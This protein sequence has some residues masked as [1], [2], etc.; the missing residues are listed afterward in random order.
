MAW[1]PSHT[2]CPARAK[3]WEQP[4]S[5]L[6][7]GS[8][9]GGVCHWWGWRGGE[10]GRAQREGGKALRVLGERRDSP[11]SR[12][13]QQSPSWAEQLSLGVQTLQTHHLDSVQSGSGIC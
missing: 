13:Q 2:S 4:S 9:C 3:H 5:P 12:T 6:H 8:G 7:E 10:H 1:S 11:L